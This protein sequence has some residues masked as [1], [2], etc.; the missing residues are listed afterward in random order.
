MH[1][2]GGLLLLRP[3]ELGVRG[4]GREESSGGQHETAEGL[5][6][7]GTGHIH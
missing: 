5:E 1:R 2:R 3:G 7:G 6:T 4:G